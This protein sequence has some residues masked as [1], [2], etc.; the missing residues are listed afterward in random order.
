MGTRTWPLLLETL[1]PSHNQQATH[2]LML[3]NKQTA[4]T[5]TL[6]F[7]HL[8]EVLN[9]GVHERGE[10]LRAAVVLVPAVT[11]TVTVTVR[12]LAA[13]TASE[14]WEVSLQARG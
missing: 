2:A 3:T 14:L 7:P 11:V 5:Q 4:Q 6:L 9:G 12:V 1:A 13:V 8:L 10:V